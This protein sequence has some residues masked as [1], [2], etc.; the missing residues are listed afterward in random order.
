MYTLSLNSLAYYGR[1]SGF[2]LITGLTLFFGVTTPALAAN[3]KFLPDADELPKGTQS[4]QPDDTRNDILRSYVG[5]KIRF[6]QDVEC[7]V[8]GCNFPANTKIG[9]LHFDYAAY[10]GIREE[11]DPMD[12]DTIGGAA[13]RGGFIFDDSFQLKDGYKLRW[14]QTFTETL[15]GQPP[16]ETVDSGSDSPLYP[17]FTLAGVDA[18]LY[19]I[20]FDLL[21]RDITITFESAL[22]CVDCDDQNDIKYIGSFLWG[23]S[24]MSGTVTA[25]EPGLWGPPTQSFINTVEE[26]FSDIDLEPG[27]CVEKVPEPDNARV[28]IAVL[29]II[30]ALGLRKVVFRK[31]ESW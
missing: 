20:P 17:D 5:D 10:T 15:P 12:P 28:S 18:L 6:E 7:P 14:V 23:Y 4:I 11:D 24:I 21:T 2:S 1:R 25:Q 27:C 19:D 13:I 22:V 29:L 16:T 9:A 30:S 31:V 8:S 26:K 3:I